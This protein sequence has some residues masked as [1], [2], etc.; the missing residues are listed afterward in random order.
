MTR[1][2]ILVA[3]RAVNIT[4]FQKPEMYAGT[5]LVVTC[6]SINYTSGYITKGRLLEKI[7]VIQQK[8]EGAKSNGKNK[9][10]Q[11]T[12]QKE[13]T[14]TGTTRPQKDAS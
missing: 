4:E 10:K 13:A 11:T 6:A 9:N 3:G 5:H 7:Q 1:T 2:K 12:P 8:V 14:G